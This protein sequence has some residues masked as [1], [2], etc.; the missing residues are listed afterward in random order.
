[1]EHLSNLTVL[2]QLELD[3]AY[4]KKYAAQRDA[5]RDTSYKR[6]TSTREEE[7]ERT[8]AQAQGAGS[9]AH[10]T[11]DTWSALSQALFSGMTLKQ[12][13]LEA[14]SGTG[15]YR[16]VQQS[17]PAVFYGV[18][19]SGEDR[20]QMVMVFQAQMTAFLRQ[21]DWMW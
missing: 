4:A 11:T 19:K 5:E 7:R 12:A 15:T 13:T 1:M 17:E 10:P 9:D 21:E 20:Q 14:T 6:K 16:I 8:Q 3:D 2:Q 18:L